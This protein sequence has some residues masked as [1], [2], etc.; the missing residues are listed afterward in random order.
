METLEQLKELRE[1]LS[2]KLIE[3]QEKDA[4]SIALQL[5]EVE[6]KIEELEGVSNG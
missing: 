2:F 1:E 3:A 5:D 4:F 6:S